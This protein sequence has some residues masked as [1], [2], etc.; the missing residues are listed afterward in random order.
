MVTIT[1]CSLLQTMKLILSLNKS[2]KKKCGSWCTKLNLLTNLL[3]QNT[4]FA[5]FQSYWHMIIEQTSFTDGLFQNWKDKS[6]AKH[7]NTLLTPYPQPS[8][9]IFLTNIEMGY[10]ASIFLHRWY[11]SSSCHQQEDPLKARSNGCSTSIKS[12][13][14]FFYHCFP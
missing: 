14:G 11:A 7:H 10:Y 4:L 12:F 1:S 6:H 5:T 9:S 2:K 13:Q 8:L 3:L